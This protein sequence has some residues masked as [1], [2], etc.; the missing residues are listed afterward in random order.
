MFCPKMLSS[1][2]FLGTSPPRP[3]PPPPPVAPATPAPPAWPL[4]P[5]PPTG[6]AEETLVP[7]GC[8]LLNKPLSTVLDKATAAPSAAVAAAAPSTSGTCGS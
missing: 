1:L 5:L 8:K 6:G 3:P 4:P 2:S 7:P